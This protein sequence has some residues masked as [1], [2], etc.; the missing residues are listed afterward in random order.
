MAFNLGAPWLLTLYSVNLLTLPFL[1]Q[2][3][4]YHLSWTPDCSSLLPG[5]QH[6]LFIRALFGRPGR[7]MI[8]FL[9]KH[10]LDYDS[11]IADPDRAF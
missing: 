1:V 5:C 2:G 7:H 8:F 9:H 10:V 3:P 4:V 6:Q 11:L